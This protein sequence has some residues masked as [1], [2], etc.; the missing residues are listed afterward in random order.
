MTVPAGFVQKGG[1]HFGKYPL[2]HGPVICPQKEITAYP[3]ASPQIVREFVKH[4]P[5]F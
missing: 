4:Q 5:D 1:Y 3:G 2:N